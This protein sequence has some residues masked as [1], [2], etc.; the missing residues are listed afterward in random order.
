MPGRHRGVSGE[1]PHIYRK[2]FI[3]NLSGTS[4]NLNWFALG[5]KSNPDIAV[6][7]TST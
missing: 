5:F 7:L 3:N 6:N 4:A 1:F 2:A